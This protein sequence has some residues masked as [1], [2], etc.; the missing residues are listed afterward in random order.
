MSVSLLAHPLGSS[1]A[2]LRSRLQCIRSLC[3]AVGLAQTTSAT[4]LAANATAF[5]LV[6]QII[7]IIVQV[8]RGTTSHFNF[9][10]SR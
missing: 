7:I 9:S 6:V 1:P 3:M 2:S 8:V 10:T 5:G 4:G